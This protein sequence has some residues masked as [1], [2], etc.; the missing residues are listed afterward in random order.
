MTL[1]ALGPCSR[2]LLAEFTLAAGIV[3]SIVGA[4]GDKLG[5]TVEVDVGNVVTG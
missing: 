4:V 5:S 2:P 1:V 3:G